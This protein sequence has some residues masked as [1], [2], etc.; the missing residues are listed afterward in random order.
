MTREPPRPGI[1]TVTWLSVYLVVL[2]AIPSRLVIGPLGSAGALSMV[3]GLVSLGLWVIL[4]AL[5]G[6]APGRRASALHWALGLFLVAVGL[7]YAI[8]MAGPISSDEV[9]PA[10]VAL[11]ALAAW[12]GTLLLAHDGIATRARLDAFVWRLVAAGGL[13]ALLGLVQFFTRTA[14]V[15]QIAIPGLTA[16]AD[17]TIYIRNGLVRPAGTA[18]H[19]IEYGA[20]LTI[21]LP[22]AFHVALQ[23]RDLNAYLRWLPLLA[24]GTVV[25]ISSSRSAYLTAGIGLVI[26]MASWTVRARVSMIALFV[27]GITAV[28][29]AMPR[30]MRSTLNLFVGADEDPSVTSRTDSF[31]V[32]WDFF[33]EAPFFGRGMGTFL[34]KYRIFDNQYL[35]MLVSVGLVGTLALVGLAVAATL[36]MI[37][38]RRLSKT[39]QTADLAVSLI[40]AVAAGFL[41]LAFF[42][43]FA[44][45][46]TMGTLFLV[47]GL[48]G[49]LFRLSSEDRTRIG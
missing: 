15:D 2:F 46:M 28:A 40:A 11:I 1:D 23:R 47:L 12:C 19:P 41:S 16:I 17:G 37:R 33:R 29:I 3:M 31:A 9:S 32:A 8:A 10:D 4:I 30:L 39:V 38:V 13:M 45:P 22:L 34:P 25:A 21:I 43:A 49:A 5:R 27:V 24:I 18:I 36:L 35:W 6:G 42:D 7:S 26:C 20:L 44:F 48:A 14:I